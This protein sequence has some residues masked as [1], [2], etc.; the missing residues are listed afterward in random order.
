MIP[1]RIIVLA[2]LLAGAP[3]SLL[4]V[5]SAH[6]TPVDPARRPARH[7]DMVNATFDSVTAV[8]IAPAG[9]DAFH[10]IPL[11]QPLQG[12]L[13]TMTFDVPAGTCLRDL[14]VTFEGGRSMLLHRIDV[15]HSHGLRLA[16]GANKV[17]SKAPRHQGLPE[18]AT[19][20]AGHH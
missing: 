15:C 20:V 16:N 1:I 19:F 14:R 4:A 2:A 5:S 18:I 12:G 17:G 11:G 10:D 9:S 13:D 8:A 7:F 3:C 6:A